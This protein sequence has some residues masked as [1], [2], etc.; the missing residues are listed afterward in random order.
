MQDYQYKTL[1]GDSIQVLKYTWPAYG[2][3]GNPC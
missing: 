2:G 3:D 1:V